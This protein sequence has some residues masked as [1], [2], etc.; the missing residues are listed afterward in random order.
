MLSS[1][2]RSAAGGGDM[3]NQRE[4]RDV[5]VADLK[6][7]VKLV[8]GHAVLLIVTD[9]R[10]DRRLLRRPEAARGGQPSAR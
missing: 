6:S 2:T 10:G 5:T 8:A 7:G 3:A 9:G 4:E 1:G